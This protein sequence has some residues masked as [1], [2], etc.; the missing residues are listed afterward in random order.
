VN[1]FLGSELACLHIADLRREAEAR[2]RLRQGRRRKGPGGLRRAVGMRL[3]DIGLV[4]IDGRA[5]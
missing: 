3:V 2:S 4:L 1:P 5:S